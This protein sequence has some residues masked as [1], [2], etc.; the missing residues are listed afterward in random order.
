M[1]QNIWNSEMKAVA[2]RLQK[3]AEDGSHCEDCRKA[4]QKI[5]DAIRDFVPEENPYEGMTEAQIKNAIMKDCLIMLNAYDNEETMSVA[6]HMAPIAA[7]M[8]SVLDENTTH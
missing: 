8:A 1:W 5:I 3:E 2:N 4:Q 6:P 7:F